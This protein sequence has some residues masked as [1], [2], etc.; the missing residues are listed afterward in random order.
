[1][2]MAGKDPDHLDSHHHMAYRSG[3]IFDVMI[4]LAQKYGLPIRAIPDRFKSNVG[5]EIPD[6][7]PHPS[8]LLTG[9]Y[10]DGATADNLMGMVA[11]INKP[12]VVEIMTHPG[13]NDDVLGSVSGYTAVRE[14]EVGIL[15]DPHI[16][17]KLAETSVLTNFGRVYSY[18][19]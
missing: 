13:L 4:E 3:K 12:G 15:C 9:F 18:T 17:R 8:R 7:I 10:G 14:I 16:A 2:R 19:S 5:C 11:S 1:M 6:D